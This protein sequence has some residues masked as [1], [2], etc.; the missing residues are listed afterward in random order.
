MKEKKFS[1]NL[2]RTEPLRITEVQS[3]LLRVPVRPLKVDSQST[4]TAW[5]VLAVRLTTD[6]GV[7]G[8]GYQCGFGA[9]MAALKVFVDETLLPQIIGQDA[10]MHKQWWSELYLLRHHTG[11]NGPAVQGVSAPE[12]AAW[13]VMAKAGDLPLWMLLSGS[14]RSRMPCYDTNCG[15][16]GYSLDELI[17]NVKRSVDEG[18]LA[19]KV[20][21]GSEDFNE[22]LRRLEAVRQA[23]GDEVQI[24]ADVNNRWD[25]QTALK[26]APALADF[27]IAWLE[28]PLYPFDV[29]G[30]A[31]LAAAIDTPLLHGENIYE[32]LMFRDMIDA[33]AIDI[34]QPSNMK[35]SGVSPWLE[36][37]SLAKTSGKRIVPAGWTMMQIDQHLAAA[38]PHC[39]MVEWIPW[40]LEIFQEPVQFEDGDIII[41]DTPGAGTTIKPEALERYAV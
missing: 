29:R 36:V 1:E 10:R 4:L 15:W 32:P 5:D 2:I 33:G 14:C 28:E 37:A 7:E 16:L 27:D 23:V 39:W 21:I 13:D 25:L 9:A 3:F 34:V 11:L 26:C 18:F 38:T 40:I 35:L 30:H 31:E 19:V 24:A 6:S 41:S 20:K 17:D 12:V 22:D 8:W